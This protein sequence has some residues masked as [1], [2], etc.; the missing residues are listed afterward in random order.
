MNINTSIL[1]VMLLGGA[2]FLGACTEEPP[3]RSVQEFVDNPQFLEAA[4]V[5]CSR[6][7]A[8]TRYEA[9][10]IN[11]RQAASVIEAREERKR[12]EALDAISQ[13]KRDALRQNLRAAEEARRR[14][15]ELEAL[16]K[17]AEYLAQFGDSRDPD[18]GRGDT[19]SKGNEPGA[20][21][22][23]PAENEAPLSGPVPA[24]PPPAIEDGNGALVKQQ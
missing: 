10:C 2:T 4:V 16:R 11:A 19:N 3:P 7:R 1:R 23:A 24:E 15:A 5:R 18:T 12:R 8:E 9:E 6:N 13:Q 14:A 17:E 20:V 21:V 22:P